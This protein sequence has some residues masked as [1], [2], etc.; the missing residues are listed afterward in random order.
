MRFTRVVFGLTSSPFLLKGTIKIHVSKCLPVSHYT[1]VVK[2]LILNLYVDDSTNSFDTVETAMEFYEKSK[3]YLKEAN[4]NLRKW[5]TN[6]FQLKNFIDSNENN[7]RSEMDI[8]DGEA[9]VANLY[10]STSVYRKVLRLNWDTGA[11]DFI[12]DF[13][14][15][16]RTM[17]KLDITKRNIFRV[18]AMFF[19]PVGLISP[20]TLQPKLIFQELYRN[21]LE[22]DEVINDRNNFNKW[23]KFL[24]DL[25]QFRII[26]AP[27]HV[28]CCEV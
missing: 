23:N 19:H 1:D 3:S 27:R 25:G 8:S 12:F 16:S 14:N 4:F 20:I 17:E 24:N 10:G 15:I 9:Y 11:D 5:A 22:W 28:L 13:E 6:S 7:N 21:K 18:A 2:K 26:N